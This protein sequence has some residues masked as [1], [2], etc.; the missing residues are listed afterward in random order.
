MVV[1][2]LAVGC[3]SGDGGGA[4]A[5]EAVLPVAVSGPDPDVV[6]RGEED[7]LKI[8]PTPDVSAPVLE[9]VQY[10]IRQDV[11]TR[12]H[13]V[14]TTT[15]TCPAGITMKAGAVSQCTATYEGVEI[16][17]EVKISDSYKEGSSVFSYTRTPKKGLLVA[18]FVYNQ[19][20]EHYGPESGR[21]DASKPACQELPVAKAYDLGADADTGYTCQ[22]W[23]E[24][25]KNGKPG[26]VTL[27]VTTGASGGM[28]FQEVG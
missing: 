20:N 6:P 12:A 25:G 17:Y 9:K 16:P 3:S 2:L 7:R 8:T 5:A 1:G 4:K 19:L 22:Y 13:V 27:K 11:L 23:S 10:A 15:A 26:Y 28:G 24:Y 14:G 21:T 18:K